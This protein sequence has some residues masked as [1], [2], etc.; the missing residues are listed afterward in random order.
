MA[1]TAVE[2]TEHPHFSS[3]AEGRGL[4]GLVSRVRKLLCNPVPIT[5]NLRADDAE[6]P[7]GTRGAK[8]KEKFETLEMLGLRLRQ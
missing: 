3:Q 2:V 6:L 5:R 1:C 4:L 8:R 7:S